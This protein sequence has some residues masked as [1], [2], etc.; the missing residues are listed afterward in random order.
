MRIAKDFLRESIQ[1]MNTKRPLIEFKVE[2]GVI[3][4]KLGE[5]R[6]YK[7][8]TQPEEEKSP[9]YLLTTEVF[10]LGSPEV[11]LIFKKQVRQLLKGQNVTNVDVLYILVQDLLRDNAL[12][13]FNKKQATCNKQFPENLKPCL[14]DVTVQ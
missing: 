7:L 14:N 13:V 5:N 2:E 1:I 4:K 10:E 11:W 9:V 3:D 6:M 8:C 12:T